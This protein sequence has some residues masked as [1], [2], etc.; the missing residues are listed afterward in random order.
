MSD[1]YEA[2][3]PGRLDVLGG[4]ADYAGSAVLQLPIKERTY[5]TLTRRDH[6]R[7]TLTTALEATQETQRSAEIEVEDLVRLTSLDLPSW[8]RYVLGCIAIGSADGLFEARGMD[9]RVRSDVPVGAGLSS[10]AALTVATW[11]VLAQA[12]SLQLSPKRLARLAQ[13]V[14][15][16]I[17]GAPCGLMDQLAVHCGTPGELVPIMCR[18]DLLGQPFP[19]PSGWRFWA[20]DSG[21]RHSVRDDAYGTVRAACFMGLQI[22]R[23]DHGFRGQYLTEMGATGPRHAEKRAEQRVLEEL[24]ETITGREFVARYGGLEDQ[25]SRVV[26]DR[27]YPVRAATV[28]PILEHERNVMMVAALVR[29]QQ[30]PDITAGHAMNLDA[31]E[32]CGMAMSIAHMGYG[33]LG[34]GHSATDKIAAQV[35]ALGTAHGLHGA[36]VT[37]G[38]SGGSVAVLGDERSDGLDLASAL[39]VPAHRVIRVWP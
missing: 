9:L 38:G 24:P 29:L 35:R 8:S 6:E 22:L 32:Q 11:R 25:L 34:L 5:V 39:G 18:P 3:A 2:S 30:T 7:I 26:Q 31:L 33:L 13:R 10:S 37:G 27:V 16:E 36:R 23:R 20:V 4:I 15:H 28:F 14:E 1:S 12:Y 19:V 21:V 17:V